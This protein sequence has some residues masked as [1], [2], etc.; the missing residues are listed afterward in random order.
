MHLA[1]ITTFSQ[2]RK[3]LLHGALLLK[4]SGMVLTQLTKNN[5]SGIQHIPQRLFLNSKAP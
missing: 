4:H 3:T 1:K 2:S 5:F